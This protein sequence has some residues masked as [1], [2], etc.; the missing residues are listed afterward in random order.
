METKRF[1]DLELVYPDRFWPNFVPNVLIYTSIVSQPKSRLM[2]IDETSSLIRL[3]KQSASLF[4]NRQTVKVH[5]EV[6]K[7]LVYQTDSYQ[8]LA[9]RDLHEAPER[10]SEIVSGL[11]GI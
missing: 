6:L 8:L 2:P 10:I 7:Q 3:M 1:L 9:G 4:F 11:Q 5:L